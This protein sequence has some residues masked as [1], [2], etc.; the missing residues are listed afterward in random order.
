ME[1]RS[2]L[3]AGAAVGIGALGEACSA[4][5]PP[6]MEPGVMPPDMDRFL[7]DLDQRMDEMNGADFVRGFASTSAKR[8]LTDVERARLEPHDKL[9]RGMLRTLYV[10]QTFRDLPDEAQKHPGMQARM[11]HHMSEID[12]TVNDAT[13]MLAGLDDT[14]R[15]RIQSYL[16]EHPDVAMSI[17]E[18]IDERAAMAGVSGKRRLQMR[19]MMMQASFRLK[20]AAPGAVIDEYVA[21]VRRVQAEDGAQAAAALRIASRANAERVWGPELSAVP[22]DAAAGA[23]AP[24]PPAP[25]VAPQPATAPAPAPPPH[26]RK[27]GNT[28][29]VGGILMG[30]GAVTFGVST[31][32]V[33]AGGGA[34]AIGMTVGAVLFAIGLVVLIVGAILYASTGP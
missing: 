11:V 12:G 3:K 13:D 22:Q 23:A 14:Q 25:L 16:R 17:G 21:K 31:A 8:S 4:T 30:V 7:A 15:A 6:A 9:F 20:H 1:R 18:A 28:M 26:H 19:S 34:G 29:I 27:G 33:A 2:V 10:T 5:P 32:I 24:Q